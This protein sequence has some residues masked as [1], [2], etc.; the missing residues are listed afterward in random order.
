MAGFI[1]HFD[2]TRDYSDQG[3]VIYCCCWSSPA[4]S[5][6]GMSPTG[7]NPYFIVPVLETP[8]TWRSRSPYLYPAGTEWSRYTPGHWV[9]FPS[10]LTTR[11]ATVEVFH[12]TSTWDDSCCPI[13][14]LPPDFLWLLLK[15][16]QHGP[17]RK[18]KSRSH[19]ERQ[20]V[21]QS[22]LVSGVHLGPATNFSF[23][24]R[25]SFRQLLV[26]YFVASSLTR[27]RVCIRSCWWFLASAVPLGSAL[28]DEG[29]GLSFVSLLSVSVYSQS[30]YA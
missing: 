18:S 7:L 28:S 2:T 13:D 4:Q 26:C 15:A 22:F 8:S 20:S 19:Y 10:S 6:S 29:S 14:S 12:P 24:L 30:V 1:L 25:F 9:S 16:P 5:R 17:H 27:G 21:G 11:R 23:S 3:S